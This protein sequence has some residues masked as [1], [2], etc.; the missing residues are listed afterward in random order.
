[1]LVI[2]TQINSVTHWID[3]SHVYGSTIEKAN[4]LR[5]TTSGRGRL[6]T[7]VDSNGRQTLP[8]IGNNSLMYYNAGLFILLNVIYRSFSFDG[9]SSHSQVISG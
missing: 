7:S 1:M 3:A 4:E 9:F 6:K 8:F 5:D 2:E